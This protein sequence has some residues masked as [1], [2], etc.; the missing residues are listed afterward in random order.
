MRKL[1]VSALLLLTA[2]KKDN[3]TVNQS[4][5]DGKWYIH[6]VVYKQYILEGGDT[7]WLKYDVVNRAGADYFEFPGHQSTDDA[8]ML[9]DNNPVPMTYEPVTPAFFKLDA[10]FCEITHLSDSALH[11]NSLYFDGATVPDKIVVTQNFYTLGR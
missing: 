3:T 6:Q 10:S 4:T 8:V 7:A 9:W 5:Y 1:L 11:F 2:C